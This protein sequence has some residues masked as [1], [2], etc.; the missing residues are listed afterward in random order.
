MSVKY[1]NIKLRNVLMI[2]LICALFI[3][4]SCCNV[5]ASSASVGISKQTHPAKFSNCVVFDG[6][7]VSYWN[8]DI[9]W[10]K[11]KKAGI[12]FAFIRIGNTFYGPKELSVDKDSYFEQNYENARAN[13]VMV[14]VYY[15][16]AAKTVSEAKEEAAFVL[17]KLKGRDIDL[18][19]VCDAEFPPD[20]RVSHQYYKWD[21]S[22]RR[23]KLTNVSVAFLDYIKENSDYDA[24][25]YSY[26][27]IMDS[28]WDGYKYK[29]N[30]IDQKYPVWIA[31][32]SD[33]ISYPRDFEFWQYSSSGHVNGIDGRCDVNF[34]YFDKNKQTISSMNSSPIGECKI[35]LS[36]SS[37]T[38]S[39][40]QKKPAVTV[41]N[42]NGKTLKAGTDY[43]VS[44]LKNVKVGT[45]Y[46]MVT[47]IGNYSGRTYKTFK[48]AKKSLEGSKAETSISYTSTTYNGEYK[49]PSVTVKYDG[50]KLKKGTDYTVS[51]SHNKS[52]GTATVTISGTGDYGGEVIHEFTIKKAKVVFD[53]ESEYNVPCDAET[54]QIPITANS[55]GKFTYSCDNEELATIDTNGLLTISGEL[56]YFNVTI[57]CEETKNY[58]SGKITV[59]VNIKESLGQ[60]EIIISGEK[61]VYDGSPKTTICQV[62][63]EGVL[64]EE[65]VDYTL[66]FENNVN[67]GQATLIVNGAGEFAGS[68]CSE[69][70]ISKAL[71]TFNGKTSYRKKYDS[72]AFQ[73]DLVSVSGANQTYKSSNTEIATVSSYGKVRLT[74]KVGKAVI[75][76]TCAECD[77]YKAA[78]KKITIY[79]TYGTATVTTGL[80]TYTKS[81]TAQPFKINAFSNSGSA[82]VFSSSNEAIAKVTNTGRVILTGKA[83]TCTITVK[84]EKTAEWDSGKAKVKLVVAKPATIDKYINATKVASAKVSSSLIKSGSKRTVKLTY[85][86]INN[87]YFVDGFV[88]YRSTHKTYNYTKIAT[89][90][91]KTYKNKV[92]RG[93]TYYYKVKPYRIINGKTYYGKF[94]SVLKRTIK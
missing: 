49:K 71:P 12:D 31:Q 51:Y 83:G 53:A 90:T 4:I 69:F 44:Y 54:F 35:S 5:N 84:S 37:Y 23:K 65:G 68:A 57:N 75:T 93:K 26:R 8:Y 80:K 85:K 20:S 15:Y 1:I 40:G 39:G 27:S 66:E 89:T 52:A 86:A 32:Y 11:V 59:P 2:T 22:E 61:I 74:G 82:L 14:G 87:K 50:V 18:P 63:R 48:I 88:I 16:S 28:N 47:G 91:E 33:E 92:K 30:L 58:K 64:L 21:S 46:A 42:A 77:N 56:G 3:A 34:W 29:M 36:K 73:L 38:Y 94:S 72:K 62:L 43:K 78:S 13:G 70:T 67:A 7:D 25:F 76:V 45:A 6:I 41:T 55:P 17:Q 81:S 9:D 24:M 19:I 60:V 79:S 10:K